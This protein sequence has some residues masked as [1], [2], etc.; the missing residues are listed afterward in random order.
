MDF[1]LDETQQMIVSGIQQFVK[2]ECPPGLF[3]EYD[4][5][6]ECPIDLYRKLGSAG[7]LGLPI[8]KE[9]GGMGASFVEVVLAIEQLAIAM[10]AL[11]SLYFNSCVF[12]SRS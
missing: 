3:R 10:P 12:G 2:R 6:A 7:W 1:D 5:K 4:D 9:Y 11:A 8:P